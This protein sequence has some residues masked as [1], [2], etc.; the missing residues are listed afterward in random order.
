MTRLIHI[1]T[2]DNELTYCGFLFSQIGDYEKHGW[3]FR[4]TFCREILE[5]RLNPDYCAACVL[6]AVYDKS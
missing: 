1:L 5:Q 6:L 4:T 2:E 3:N